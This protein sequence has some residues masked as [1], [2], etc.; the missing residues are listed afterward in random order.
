MGRDLQWTGR[1]E[2]VWWCIVVVISM[3]KRTKIDHFL[4]Q[5]RKTLEIKLLFGFLSIARHLICKCIVFSHF[6]QNF[7]IVHKVRRASF[8][9]ILNLTLLFRT[10]FIFMISWRLR[11]LLWGLEVLIMQVFLK[12]DCLRVVI[13]VLAFTIFV[14][15]KTYVLV[16]AKAL[17]LIGMNSTLLYL[18]L[19]RHLIIFKGLKWF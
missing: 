14:G 2:F 7:V 10:G 17:F 16:C 18:A 13:N 5:L 12:I 4:V 19:L 8:F 9:R 1:T 3:R 11:M 6:N 15:N